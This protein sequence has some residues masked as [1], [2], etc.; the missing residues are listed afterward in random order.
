MRATNDGYIITHSGLERP[1]LYSSET[2]YLGLHI[3]NNGFIGR[4]WVWMH[5]GEEVLS[6]GAWPT[7]PIFAPVE[8]EPQEG[9]FKAELVYTGVSENTARLLYREYVD[10]MARSAFSQELEYDLSDSNI[11]SFRSISIE[12][13]EATSSNMR[14][15]VISDEDLPW[16]P[17]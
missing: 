14:F 11:I 12:V 4:G 9:S 8:A 13:L 7:G 6:T 5:S 3:L 15:R 2:T 17:R 10:D 1:I 16:L